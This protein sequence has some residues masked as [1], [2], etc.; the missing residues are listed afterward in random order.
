MLKILY[1]TRNRGTAGRITIPA[2]AALLTVSGAGL[3]AFPQ[4]SKRTE[5]GANLTI[6][7]YQFDDVRSKKVGDVTTLRQTVSTAEEEVE[8]I[9]RTYGLEELKPRHVRSVGLAEGESFTD[10]V[11]MNEKPLSFTIVP[12]GITREGV[13]FDFTATCAGQVLMELKGVSANNYETVM[14]RGGRGEFGV[15]EFAGPKGIESVPEKRALLVTV[16]PTVIAV[17]GLQNRPGDLSRPTDMYGSV[18][19]LNADDVFIMP[20]V[21]TRIVPRFATGMPKGSITLEAV[22]TPEGR[23]T[24]VKVMDSPDP[25]YNAKAIEA[26]R[27]Y[28]FAPATLNGKPTYATWRE[29]IVFTR[30][31][32]P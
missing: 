18:V 12:R 19:R 15:R 11:G 6:A 3:S 28:K 26:Y 7:L 20:S 21:L 30:P 4:A 5:Y 1:F 8:Y 25:A 31:S 29:T 27:Q 32:A 10:A 23:V 24:N 14:L 13:K 22:I 9:T 16:T 2:L 17:R